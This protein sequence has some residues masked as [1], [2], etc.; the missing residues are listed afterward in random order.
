MRDSFLRLIH[1]FIVGVGVACALVAAMTGQSET[2]T[3]S[4][5]SVRGGVYT[6]EQAARGEKLYTEMCSQCH[7]DDLAGREQALPL[8]G[9][10]FG[11]VWDGQ[12][13]SAL[14]GRIRQMPPNKPNSLSRPQM[15]DILSY[16]LSFDGLPAG[17]SPLSDEQ[18]VWTRI[19]YQTPLTN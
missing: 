7:G 17:M 8:A 9:P 19:I 11:S 3:A 18:S 10:E 5:Q 4:T 16:I 14:L 1:Q 13:I 6:K 2:V 15:V 12:P